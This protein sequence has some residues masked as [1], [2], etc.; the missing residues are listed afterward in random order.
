MPPSLTVACA[1]HGLV[2]AAGTLIG[3]LGEGESEGL[4]EG[5]G[6]ER[7]GDGG[8]GEVRRQKS[9]KPPLFPLFREPMKALCPHKM[10]TNAAVPCSCGASQTKAVSLPWEEGGG[11]GGDQEH[12]S[13][14]SRLSL[15]GSMLVVTAAAEHN[16]RALVSEA[17]EVKCP[18]SRA[19]HAMP[20]H[21]CCCA[22][23]PDPWHINCLAVQG[24]AGALKRKHL[25]NTP[26][27]GRLGAELLCHFT[28]CAG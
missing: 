24:L 22:G 23:T 8:N 16:G 27:P 10:H 21:G 12:T 7:T 19:N 3:S 13:G 9:R 25:E 2:Y 1:S 6:G 18:P 26:G 4:S 15:V 14:V 17:R 5:E 20:T 11:G 28:R